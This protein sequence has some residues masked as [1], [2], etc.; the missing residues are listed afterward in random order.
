M[1]PPAAHFQSSRYTCSKFRWRKRSALRL[2]ICVGDSSCMQGPWQRT[3]GCGR[4]SATSR[5]FK[6]DEPANSTDCC[7]Q[8]KQ[9]SKNQENFL[10]RTALQRPSRVERC[11]TVDCFTVATHRD[12]NS[13]LQR[14]KRHL[15]RFNSGSNA[16]ASALA[17]WT[18]WWVHKG[19]IS[20][21]TSRM[22]YLDSELLTVA[23]HSAALFGLLATG[24]Q[25]HSHSPCR[26]SLKIHNLTDVTWWP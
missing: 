23:W 25:D 19:S 9:A 22:I 2:P 24:L 20:T 5:V 26:E 4:L 11:T 18:C 12:E 8:N 10:R 7:S 17:Y 14:K 21:I 16:I 13:A 15:C 1:K 6:E 3:I